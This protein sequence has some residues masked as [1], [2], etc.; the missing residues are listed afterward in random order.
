MRVEIIVDG[1]TDGRKAKRY[2]VITCGWTRTPPI[3]KRSRVSRNRRRRPN[4]F[5]SS[6]SCSPRFGRHR[7]LFLAYFPGVT[8]VQ[9]I[10][11]QCVLRI[12]E[13]T[14]RTHAHLALGHTRRNLL[15]TVSSDVTERNWTICD[16]WF[17][18]RTFAPHEANTV[19]NFENTISPILF[20]KHN[21]FCTK[22]R[23]VHMC[24]IH[25]FTFILHCKINIRLNLIFSLLSTR[26]STI[27]DN[28]S[29]FYTKRSLHK[30]SVC[31]QTYKPARF[32][33]PWMQ[34][35]IFWW[36]IIILSVIRKCIK[37]I[38]LSNDEQWLF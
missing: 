32:L 27:R 17:G 26:I 22:I 14:R 5:R 24:R 10:I 31:C 25:C 35:I 23:C 20:H 3:G 16:V 15:A 38:L 37:N 29:D 13:C 30:T 11:A 21:V 7:F 8:R 34:V 9:S 6:I 33:S 28:H 2:A 19:T 12:P 4:R 1:R 18:Y 36:H